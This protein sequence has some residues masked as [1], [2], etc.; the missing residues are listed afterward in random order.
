[1]VFIIT[2]DFIQYCFF[3]LSEV[4]GKITAKAISGK[5]LES[6]APIAEEIL[7][8]PVFITSDHVVPLTSPY[9]ADIEAIIKDLSFITTQP[10]RGPDLV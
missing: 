7:A 9:F 4:G 6:Q 2:I 10:T 8:L 5:I 3:E 1:M